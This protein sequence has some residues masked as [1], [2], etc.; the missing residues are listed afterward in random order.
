MFPSSNDSYKLYSGSIRLNLSIESTSHSTVFFSR[1]K[2]ANNTI[3][4][5]KRMGSVEFDFFT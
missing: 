5:D 4:S 3:L 1:N 2:S